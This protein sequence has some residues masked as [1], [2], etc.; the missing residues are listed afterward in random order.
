MAERLTPALRPL[1]EHEYAD[2]LEALNPE[3]AVTGGL[4]DDPKRAKPNWWWRRPWY[5]HQNLRDERAEAF[6]DLLYGGVYEY[7]YVARVTT[8][9][10]FVVPPARAEEMYHPETYGRTGTDRVVVK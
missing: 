4:P 5:R 1:P 2:E 3:L 8:P 9:G 6:T 10:E 7:T